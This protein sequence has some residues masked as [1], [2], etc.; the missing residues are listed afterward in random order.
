MQGNNSS[1]NE[2][3]ALLTESTADTNQPRHNL[4]VAWTRDQS[5]ADY[6]TI[7]ASVIGGPDL[8]KGSDDTAITKTELFTFFDESDRLLRIEYERG[9]SDIVNGVDVGM[10]GGISYNLCDVILDNTDGRFTFGKNSTIGT[11][12]IANRP[13]IVNLGYYLSSKSFSKLVPVFKGL[14]NTPQEDKLA[15][16]V[17]FHCSDYIATINDAQMAVA[18]YVDKRTD[19][20]IKDILL[21]LGFSSDQFALDEGLNTISY[22]WF[23]DTVKAGDRIRQIVESEG[24]HFYQDELGV[25]RF[26][27]RRHYGTAPHNTV[28]HTI[29]KNDIFSW[30]ELESQRIVNRCT[31]I[32]NPRTVQSS[33]EVW[34]Q[35]Q[36]IQLDN[37]EV[38]TVWAD[39]ENPVTGTSTPVSGT[40]FIANTAEDGSGTDISSS[41][42]LTVTTFAKSAKIEITNSSGVIAYITFLRLNGTPAI[43][44]SPIKE[45]YEDADSI[46]RY[47]RR[48]LTI[49]SD[50]IDDESYSYY[51][52]RAIVRKHKERRRQ[53]EVMINAVP[54]LQVKDYV[55]IF[56]PDLQTNTNGWYSTSLKSRVRLTI[57]ADKIDGD[58]INFPVYVDLSDMPDHFFKHTQG[59]GSDIVV[60]SGDGSTKLNRELV[61]IDTGAKTGQMHFL[62]SSVSSTTDTDFYIYYNGPASFE[63]NSTSVWTDYIG[64]W[65]LDDTPTGS[66][67]DVSDSSASG[68]DGDTVGSMGSADLVSGQVGDSIDFDGSDDRVEIAHNNAMQLD[69]FTISMWLNVDALPGG[70]EFPQVLYK[71]G[72][73]QINLQQN[74][75][76]P[77]LT[78]SSG[79][80]RSY[81]S[82]T[83]LTPGSWDHLVCVHKSGSQKIYLNGVEVASG[84]DTGSLDANFEELGFADNGAGSALNFNGKMDEIR[85]SG[86]FRESDFVTAEYNNQSDT[87]TFYTVSRDE[88]PVFNMRVMRIRGS[89][90]GAEYV[91]K[92]LLREITDDE[93]D[94]WF[95]IGTSTIDSQTEV[96]G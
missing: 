18:M 56:D 15:R 30:S 74:T 69:T 4:K 19:E 10:I 51:L 48:E 40:D 49:E 92:L 78:V 32:G 11:A 24:G 39:F 5:N 96:I 52:A 37:G 46:N 90:V 81:V 27:T 58:L 70:G 13:T 23:D 2:W 20:I 44:Q 80:N 61:S 57:D 82:T 62:A 8:I 42:S 21:R 47:G 41:V 26:E 1:L 45:V 3:T 65:H 17:G 77:Y 38:K 72:N 89:M 7:G 95:I 55:T 75:G 9:V 68:F 34:R 53:V 36:V 59:D 88:S 85:I 84:T 71:G 73:Y 54:H 22:A 66:S 12:L 16:T 86:Q 33:Q 67:G 43:V 35:S 6:F 14:S 28:V 83:A 63:S 25:I 87:S 60:T 29:H 91:Q 76:N 93:T 94:S 31:V 64:V 50:F 79:G